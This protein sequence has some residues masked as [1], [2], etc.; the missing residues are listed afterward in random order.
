MAKKKLSPA[1]NDPHPMTR[2]CRVFLEEVAN[3]GIKLAAASHTIE[4]FDPTSEEFYDA[5]ATVD[6]AVLTLETKLPAL[7]KALKEL[8]RM[9]PKE[10]AA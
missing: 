4:H 7:R 10:K 3:E 1:P 2:H 8:D 5:M 9:W 6:V